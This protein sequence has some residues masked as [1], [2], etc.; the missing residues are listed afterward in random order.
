[1]DNIQS[2]KTLG[3][4]GPGASIWAISGTLNEI[5]NVQLDSRK[6][7]EIWKDTGAIVSVEVCPEKAVAS[8]K[9]EED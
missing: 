9:C 1:M 3:I 2:R 5:F 8:Y 6:R 4:V 7:T